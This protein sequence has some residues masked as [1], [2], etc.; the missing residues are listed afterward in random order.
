MSQEEAFVI[1]TRAD[2]DRLI[3]KLWMG[4][5]AGALLVFL[6]SGSTAITMWMLGYDSGSIQ[7]V[8]TVVF[9]VILLPYGLGFVAPMLATSLIKMSLGV[10]MSRKGLEV[11]EK[12][13]ATLDEIKAEVMPVVADMKAV[14]GD[15]KALVD[16]VKHKDFK[17]L[18]EFV[19]GL[20]KNGTVEALATNIKKLAERVQVVVD[21]PVGMGKSKEA[22]VEEIRGAEDAQGMVDL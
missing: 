3:R 1:P 16:Q 12:T 14:L 19:D 13:A 22:L 20:S 7:H 9:Q 10:E 6:T 18:T 4:C 5:I 8:S 11:A 21:G 15:I 2:H 17:K